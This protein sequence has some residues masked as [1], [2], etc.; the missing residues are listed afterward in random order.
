MA[1]KKRI[2]NKDSVKRTDNYEVYNFSY[3]N[4]KKHCDSLNTPEEKIVYLEYAKK[5][6]TNNSVGLDL[7]LYMQGPTFVQKIENEIAFIRKEMELKMKGLPQPEIN[8]KI[9]WLKNRQDFVALFDALMSAGFISYKKD[10]YVTLCKHFSWIDDEMKPEQLKHL[11]N[12][13]KNKDFYY[14]E[15]DEMKLIL[16][17][18]SNKK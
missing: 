1:K 9:V 3:D 6:K 5:E 18:I 12:N 7:E 15:S 10:K 16:E 13:I 4:V 14:Q 8:E 2:T 17:G 11:R